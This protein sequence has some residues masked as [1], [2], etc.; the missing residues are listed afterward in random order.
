MMMNGYLSNNNNNNKEISK[1][2]LAAGSFRLLNTIL[3]KFSQIELYHLIEEEKEEEEEEALRL[4]NKYLKSNKSAR[5]TANDELI[6][7]AEREGE[8]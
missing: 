4:T 3:L 1:P 5:V 7:I 6:Q 2:K 8:R